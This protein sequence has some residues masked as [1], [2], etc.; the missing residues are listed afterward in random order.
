M[1]GVFN[2]FSYL[3]LPYMFRAFSTH[4][5]EALCTNSAVVLVSWVLCQRLRQGGIVFFHAGP[6]AVT[7][8]RRLEP[9]PNL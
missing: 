6:V 5:Q 9:L 4:L 3:H 7:L 8:P 1:H 2:L